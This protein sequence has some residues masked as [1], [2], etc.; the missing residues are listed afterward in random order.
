MVETEHRVGSHHFQGL[1]FA[2]SSLQTH[3]LMTVVWCFDSPCGTGFPVQVDTSQYL[4]DWCTLPTALA[5][6]AAASAAT[7]SGSAGASSGFG[8]G[9]ASPACSAGA[10]AA[11]SSEVPSSFCAGSTTAS[12][13]VGSSDGCSACNRQRCLLLSKFVAHG[14]TSGPNLLPQDSPPGLCIQ[15][16]LVRF[17]LDTRH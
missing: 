4:L 3:Q 13:T 10:A 1:E 14:P 9:A 8:S 7:T 5:Y 17:S 16:G 15:R 6:S 11:G 2:I 12:S